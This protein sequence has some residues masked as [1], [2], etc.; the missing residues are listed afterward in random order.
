MKYTI[1]HAELT[2]S[3]LLSEIIRKSFIDVAQRFKLTSENCPTHPSNCQ[4]EWVEKAIYKGVFYYLLE[5][6]GQICGCVALEKANESVGYLE[7][8]SVMP[9][10]RNRGLGIALVRHVFYEAKRLA[11]NRVEI[12]IIAEQTDLEEWYQKRGF[13]FIR[14]ASYDHLPFGVK[15]LGIEYQNVQFNVNPVY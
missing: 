3:K 5:A 7:R 8:L 13:V 4:A 14:Q 15:F 2:D 1:R 9:E 11:L 6:E 10:F 12:A